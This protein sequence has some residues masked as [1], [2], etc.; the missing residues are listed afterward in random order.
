VSRRWVKERGRADFLARRHRNN[1]L[2]W[3]ISIACHLVGYI[4]IP[5]TRM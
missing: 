5:Q 3:Q 4:G 1:L 2:T